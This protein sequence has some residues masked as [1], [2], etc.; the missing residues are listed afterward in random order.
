MGEVWAAHDVELDCPV[1]IEILSGALS[2][3]GEFKER[4]RR[5]AKTLAKFS[6]PRV[7][8]ILAVDE[9]YRDGRLFMVMELLEGR[10][11]R[12][13]LDELAQ[14]GGVLGHVTAALHAIQI[15]DGL[16]TGR[17]RDASAAGGG[18]WASWRRR[19]GG[20]VM[21]TSCGGGSSMRSLAFRASLSSV[22]LAGL[23][24]HDLY[25]AASACRARHG[26]RSGR[27]AVVSAPEVITTPLDEEEL[28]R[29]DAMAKSYGLTREEMIVKLLRIGLPLLEGKS[30]EAPDGGKEGEP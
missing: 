28:G 9:L 23:V 20:L 25:H 10:T 1:A 30:P 12:A 11:L 5:E 21:R 19:H 29:I 16:G 15:L 24:L 3:D 6:H 13:I 14:Q 18:L 7:V 22:M 26:T 2:A 8:R 17:E 27:G 4:F